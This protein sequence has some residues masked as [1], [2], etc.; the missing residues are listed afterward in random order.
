MMLYV[1]FGF[2]RFVVSAQKRDFNIFLLGH[3]KLCFIAV[4]I[5]LRFPID[6]VDSEKNIS[7][8]FKKERFSSIEASNKKDRKHLSHHKLKP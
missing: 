1:Q 3:V 7:N 4:G 5:F 8:A 2:N 6:A